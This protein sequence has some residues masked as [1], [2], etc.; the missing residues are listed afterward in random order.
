MLAIG[1]VRRQQALADRTTGGCDRIGAGPP[2]YRDSQP[3][4]EN[5]RREHPQTSR[6]PPPDARGHGERHTRAD[7]T[8]DED[9]HKKMR[10]SQSTTAS[11]AG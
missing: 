3:S 2:R 8:D 7:E 1:R 5:D 4:E 10:S 9:P 11:T 6:V